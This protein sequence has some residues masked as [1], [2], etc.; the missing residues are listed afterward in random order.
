MHP[1]LRSPRTPTTAAERPIAGTRAWRSTR[2]VLVLAVVVSAASCLLALR[3]AGGAPGPVPGGLPDAGAATGWALRAV[4]LL[5]VLA[6]VLTVGSLLVGAVLLPHHRATLDR[7]GPDR[8]GLDRVVRRS[9]HRAGDAACAWALLTALELLLT[10]SD[11]AGVPLV[12]L[13][14]ELIVAVGSTPQGGALVTSALLAAAVAALSRLVS[15]RGQ[16]RWPLALALAALVPPAL[17]GHS[18]AAADPGSAGSALLVHVL[19]ASLWVGGLA[20]LLLHLRDSPAALA[21]AVPRF[22]ALALGSYLALVASGL[23][24]ATTRLGT[25][26]STWASGYGALVAAKVVAL[27]VLGGL[28]LTHRRRTLP[29]LARGGGPRAFLVL[30]GGE[31]VVMGAALGL[32]AALSRTPVPAAPVTGDTGHGSGHATLPGS[33]DPVSLEH[34]ALAWRPNALVLLVVGLA[35]AAYLRGVRSLTRGGREW[36]RGRTAAFVGGLAVALVDLCS[37]VAAYAP[38]L[39]SVQV[40]QLL[41]ATLVVPALL[42]LGAP[43]TLWK[44]VGT[45]RGNDAATRLVRSPAVSALT[46]PVS[47]AALASAFLLTVYRTPLIEVSLSSFWVHLLVLGVGTAVGLLALWPLLG[48]DAVASSPRA[49]ERL[50]C[51]VVLVGCLALLAVQLRHGDRLLAGRWFLELRWGWVDPV[52]DQR[53]AG[54]VVGGVALLLILLVGAASAAARQPS[55]GRAT[56]VPRSV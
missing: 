6:G 8:D 50:A 14:R 5:G 9:A 11:T 52:A 46:T 45:L 42:V 48:V 13:D 23:L 26:P 47:G 15:G 3:L 31:L 30:A 1:V 55:G 24:T 36:S 43:V 25:S 20:G 56:S 34:L 32:A 54:L 7:H 39:V 17:A 37:G 18:A 10:V 35:L 28:G 44:R 22:S 16:L 53:L 19:A 38:A 51:L 49:V 41:V 2:R 12:H 4:H 40:G 21:V 33:V 29:R 27:L